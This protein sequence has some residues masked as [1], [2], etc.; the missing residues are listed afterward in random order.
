M[1]VFLNIGSNLGN[2][3]LN[4][5]KA[6][7]ALEKEFGYFELSHSVESAAQ[8]FKSP[9]KFM[10]VGMMVHSDLEPLELLA[11]IQKIEK[12]LSDGAHRDS[13]GRYIDREIDIDIIAI[14]EQVIDTPELTVPH[15]RMRERMFVLQ[16]MVELAAG[17]KHPKTGLTPLEMMAELQKKESN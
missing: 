3:M 7:S 9:R 1:I 6:V 10:N 13:K 12:E 15:P 11:R 14:D 2:R 16:P 5:S 17:W 4:I 8:G